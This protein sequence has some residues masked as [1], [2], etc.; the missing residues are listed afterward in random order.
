MEE[1]AAALPT[2]QGSFPSGSCIFWI[3]VVRREAIALSAARRVAFKEQ[4]MHT[5]AGC[6]MRTGMAAA[7]RQRQLL[8]PIA[9][10]SKHGGIQGWE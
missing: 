5:E 2:V 7:E 1:R 6:E 3:Q 10:A 4:G 8:P 9:E